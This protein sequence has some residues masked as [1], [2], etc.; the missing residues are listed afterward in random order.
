MPC[1][2]GTGKFSVVVSCEQVNVVGRT[3]LLCERSWR[4]EVGSSGRVCADNCNCCTG[5]N[6]VRHIVSKN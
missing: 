4:C 1:A 3:E 2:A 6:G 5:F